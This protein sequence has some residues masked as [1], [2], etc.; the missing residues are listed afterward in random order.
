[1]ARKRRIEEGPLVATCV[2]RLDNI[3]QILTAAS[4]D[5]QAKKERRK[6]FGGKCKKRIVEI[7]K[8]DLKKREN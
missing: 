2:F 8:R 5:K 7:A 6:R 3:E 1:M 4:I